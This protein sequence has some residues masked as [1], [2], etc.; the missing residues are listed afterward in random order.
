MKA[1]IIGRGISGRAAARLAEAAGHE[2]EY[3]EDNNSIP[4][5]LPS[6]IF[7][8]FDLLIVSPGVPPFSPVYMAAVDSGIELIS[9]MEFGARHFNGSML[10]IT[11]TNG[12]TTTTELTVHLLQALGVDAR[13]AGNI[14]FPLCD[15]CADILTGKDS[16]GIL[17]VIEVSSFQLEKCFTF[18]PYAAVLL[19][20]TSDHLNRYHD[21]MDEYAATKFKIFERVPAERRVLG[22]TLCESGEFNS[23]LP[24]CTGNH[25]TARDGDLL[26]AGKSIIR[27]QDT[28]LKGP[29]NLENLAAAL[30]LVRIYLGDDALFS[31]ALKNAICEFAPG[32]HRLEKVAEHAGVVFI[33]DSKA[34]NPA[35]VIAALQT[36]STPGKGNV[37]IILG[38]L[39]KEMDFSSLRNV[40][41]YLKAAF[42]IGQCR[43]KIFDA[44]NSSLPCTLFDTFREAVTAAARNSVAGDIVLLSPACASMDMFK[45]Y[46]DRG[47][48]FRDIVNEQDIIQK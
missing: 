16:A 2:F 3:F 12:K 29:H 15:I 8:G 20:I 42:I 44:L 34:T 17:P 22:L 32:R 30:E 46:K 43:Q 26:Y 7:A 35:S 45:D 23:L 47:D 31:P 40:A 4:G 11:G 5:Q 13:P 14:G 6:S 33:N 19:N 39:D 18:N 9:E 27:Q 24:V 21:C 38:G 25:I 28:Q 1:G 36:V 48:Q 37:N 41:G 10:A